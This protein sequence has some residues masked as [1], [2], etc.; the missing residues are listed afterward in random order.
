[1][2]QLSNIPGIGKVALELL[3]VAGFHDLESLAM[4]EET[5]VTMEL[6]RAN[7]ILK[8]TKRPPAL[9]NVTKWIAAA[10]EMIGPCPG[11]EA[12]GVTHVNYEEVVEVIAMLE[13]APF[14]I[15]L[16]AKLLQEKQLAVSDIPSAIMLNHYPGDLDIRVDEKIP[17]APESRAR[18]HA[19]DSVK[20][21]EATLPR[22]GIDHSKIKPIGAIGDG[23][24][25]PLKSRPQDEDERVTLIRGP[26]LETNTGRNRDSR[27]FIH[28][29]LH[30]N[31]L[32]IAMGAI[33]CLLLVV[34]IPLAIASAGL[35]LLSDLVPLHFTWVPKWF[36]AFPLA[37]PFFGLIYLVWGI[38]G[39]CRVCGQKLFV[40]RVCLKNSKAH[41]LKFLG[42]I[43]PLS[44]HLLIFKWFR[45]TYCGT[46]IRLKK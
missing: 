39:S 44:F 17:K 7:E 30:N 15:P 3:E 43:I 5:E 29:V 22:I 33:T 45:C 32:S 21:A 13:V 8:I 38:H 1:M 26:R 35:L 41:H 23:K 6:E 2:T 19:S 34:M 28:G 9:A 12:K 4:A 25:K 46:P 27:W 40:P 31:P 42:Y 20:L 11:A 14:A 36:L 16:P 18:S 37:L 10:R 24:I